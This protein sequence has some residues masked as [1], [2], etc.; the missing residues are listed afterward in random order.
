MHFMNIGTL[1]PD[2]ELAPDLHVVYIVDTGNFGRQLKIFSMS[3]GELGSRN[4]TVV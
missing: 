3:I 2:T 1:F 4:S